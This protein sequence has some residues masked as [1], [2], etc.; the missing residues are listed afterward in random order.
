MLEQP[1]DTFTAEEFSLAYKEFLYLMM[2]ICRETNK[3][4]PAFFTLNYTRVELLALQEKLKPGLHDMITCYLRK[5]ILSIDSALEWLQLH[6][7]QISHNEL[8]PSHNE[9]KPQWTAGVADLVE[10]SMSLHEKK[11]I[12]NGE[13]SI[14]AVVN[15]FFNLFE[16]KPGN[17]FSTYGVMRTRA[18]SRTL[19]LDGLKRSLEAKMDR[20]DEKET[21]RN[22]R[23]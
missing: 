17:F 20:D 8:Q 13:E 3:N 15:F 16:L 7:G 10:L 22:Q 2:E 14:T 21:R 12:N 11:A 18:D 1:D 9:F 19:F 23:Y 5:A 6:E 4:V